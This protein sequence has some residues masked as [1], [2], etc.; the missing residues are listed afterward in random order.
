MERI[1]CVLS[2]YFFACCEKAGK[3]NLSAY[4]RAN[5]KLQFCTYKTSVRRL[6]II[7]DIERDKVPELTQLETDR[8]ADSTR[9]SV[10]FD[11]GDGHLPL[12][13][14]SGAMVEET[15]ILCVL[16]DLFFDYINK[17]NVKEM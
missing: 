16:N 11:L 17:R 8:Q 6:C 3:P 15:P 5:P 10:I 9:L 13:V 2:P 14:L 7:F 1:S 12:F 4:L